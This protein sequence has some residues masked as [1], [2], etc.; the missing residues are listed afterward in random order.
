MVVEQWKSLIISRKTSAGM[1]C[2]RW[3]MSTRVRSWCSKKGWRSELGRPCSNLLSRIRCWYGD[4]RSG[5]G[6]G[7][8]GSKWG[9]RQVGG[10]GGEAGIEAR[11]RDSWWGGGPG[12]RLGQVLTNVDVVHGPGKQCRFPLGND[13]VVP[14]LSFWSHLIPGGDLGQESPGGIAVEP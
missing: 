3:R 7:W 14:V 12:S 6:G 11:A 1:V 2:E 10:G 8:N 5:G 13:G 9:A 4:S